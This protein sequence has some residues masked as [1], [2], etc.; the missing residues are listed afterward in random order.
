MSQ[1]ILAHSL[2]GD[3]SW[4]AEAEVIDYSLLVRLPWV[5]FDSTLKSALAI[6]QCGLD[7]ESHEIVM[8]LI[9]Y[10]RI[11]HSREAMEHLY[12]QARG[13]DGAVIKPYDYKERFLTSML[14]YFPRTP[15][16]ATTRQ[17]IVSNVANVVSQLV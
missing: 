1:I 11:F 17:V 4:L 2:E 3:S 12:N 15:T 16:M 5:T 13:R 14:S 6:M 8:G 10:N 9:D 7:R